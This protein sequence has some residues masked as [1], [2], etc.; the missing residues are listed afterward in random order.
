MIGLLVWWVPVIIMFVRGRRVWG[1]I[2]ILLPIINLL[3]LYKVSVEPA[4]PDSFWAERFYGENMVRVSQ[5]RWPFTAMTR[6]THSEQKQKT[7]EWRAEKATKPSLRS[8]YKARKRERKAKYKALRRSTPQVAE[9]K[10]KDRKA[11]GGSKGE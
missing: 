6:G 2:S 5:E 10:A 7:A 3:V 8:R 11:K 9:A 1:L 4:K